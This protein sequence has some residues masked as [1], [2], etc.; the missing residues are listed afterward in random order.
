MVLAQLPSPS[1]VASGAAYAAPAPAR[2]RRGPWM[3]AAASFLAV[4]ILAV[5]LQ[6]GGQSQ[7]AGVEPVAAE[8]APDLRDL[9]GELDL[10][11]EGTIDAIEETSVSLHFYTPPVDAL[12]PLLQEL[13]FSPDTMDR[14]RNTQASD[15]TLTATAPQATASWDYEPDESL[16]VVIQIT[17]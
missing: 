14:I 8:P 7:V 13:G 2:G 5:W 3:V 11:E 10:W 4:G 12:E 16:S 9:V 17:D 15:G 6:T 1:P